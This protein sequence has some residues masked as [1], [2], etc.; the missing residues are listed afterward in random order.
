MSAIAVNKLMISAGMQTEFRDGKGRPVKEPTEKGKP[1]AV[2][3][4]TEKRNVDGTPVRQLKW[5]SDVVEVL[6]AEMS[7]ATS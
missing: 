6:R 3:Q 7:E 1:F 5:S 2:W 4:D